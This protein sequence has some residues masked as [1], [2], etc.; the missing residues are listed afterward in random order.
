MSWEVIPQIANELRDNISGQMSWEIIPQIAN[1][2]RDNTS[3]DKW[4]NTSNS[5]WVER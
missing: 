1:E 4:V 2:L 3:K 5:K